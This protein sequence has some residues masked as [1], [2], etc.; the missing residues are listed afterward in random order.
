[1]EKHHHY[2][3]QLEISHQKLK[4]VEGMGDKEHLSRNKEKYTMLEE[5]TKELGYK[6]G[7]REPSA[8]TFCPT[9]GEGGRGAQRSCRIL[10]HLTLIASFA[11]VPG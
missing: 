8:L 7:S 9:G 3:K 6:V 2:Q 4:H 10:T 1:M 5:K 11:W